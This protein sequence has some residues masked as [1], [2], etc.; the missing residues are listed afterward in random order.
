PARLRVTITG[1]MGPVFTALRAAVAGGL[2]GV[3]ALTRPEG[4]LLGLAIVVA[5]LL[6]RA[7]WSLSPAR[8]ATLAVVAV[9]G[10][11]VVAG[12]WM[13]RKRGTRGTYI[14]CIGI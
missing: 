11:A 14:P 2:A 13:A 6:G 3:L 12:P 4:L 1:P 9:A 8:R 5:W 10:F 7:A